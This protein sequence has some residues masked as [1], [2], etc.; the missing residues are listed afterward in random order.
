MK[1]G[2][3]WALQ[4]RAAD[5]LLPPLP[6]SSRLVSAVPGRGQRGPGP[7]EEAIA[8]SR[9]PGCLR[10]GGRGLLIFQIFDSHPVNGS[11]VTSSK[12][13]SNNWGREPKTTLLFGLTST[14]R[15]SR[16]SPPAITEVLVPSAA[17][18]FGGRGGSS[19]KGPVVSLF[20]KY[21]LRGSLDSGLLRTFHSHANCEYSGCISRKQ[22]METD[23]A[24]PLACWARN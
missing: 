13:L 22:P 24:S 16:K 11:F 9:A 4:G 5:V 14:D 7:W 15:E 23:S 12:S 1:S 18:K 8:H 6:P 10:L 20:G 17:Q 2:S 3:Q 21:D 19:K